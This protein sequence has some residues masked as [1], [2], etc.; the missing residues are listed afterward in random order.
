MASTDGRL[1]TV[2]SRDAARSASVEP[3]DWRRPS[4]FGRENV[5]ALSKAHDVFSRRMSTALGSVLRSLVQVEP[6]GIEQMTYDDYVRSLPNPNISAVLTIPP[7]PGGVLMETNVGFALQLVDRMLG[8]R[9]LPVELR[10][11]TDL[12]MPLIRDLVAVGVRSLNEALEPQLQVSAE[13]GILETNPQMVQITSPSDMVLLL[14]Y[15][16]TIAQG[17]LT[18]GLLTLCYPSATLAPVLE[19]LSNAGGV[20]DHAGGAAAATDV[21][22]RIAAYLE[23]VEVLMA[24]RLADSS[25]KSRDLLALG[26]GDVLRLD[27]RV[28]Q[29]AVA[30]IGDTPV[31]TGHLGRRGRRLG[32][33]VV[34]VVPPVVDPFA[35]AALENTGRSLAPSSDVHDH[36]GVVAH[37]D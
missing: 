31:L 13:M 33:Q 8:G 7:L 3:F 36:T 26:V 30:K 24:V 25:V 14:S 1:N 15:R 11:P 19:R 20:G 28:G 22:D 5:R 34:E 21:S 35:Q 16:L 17:E 2:G 10:R 12:E 29:P 37:V 6:L 32:L 9:G 18:E 23:D 27:H 4:K